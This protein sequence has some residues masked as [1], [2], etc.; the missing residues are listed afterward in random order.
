MNRLEGIVPA[1]MTPFKKSEEVDHEFLKQHL[2]FLIDSGVDS[3]YILGTAAA[4]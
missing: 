3:F 1:L 2:D 4:D